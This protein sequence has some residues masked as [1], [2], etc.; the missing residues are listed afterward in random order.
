METL[1]I[2]L[3]PGVL[4]GIL[5][6]LLIAGWPIRRTSIVVPRRLDNASPALIN[7]A[8]IKVEGLGGLG[9]VAAV[10][11]VAIAD[12]RIRTAILIAAVLG[13]G[14]AALL[15]LMRRRNGALP[16]STGGPD[17]RSILHLDGGQSRTS[18]PTSAGQGRGD[19][20]AYLACEN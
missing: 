20:P 6:A 19:R 18:T 15:I 4:G 13:A 2:V 10:I 14:L 7:M 11:A 1:V 5:L 12:G 3:V 9:L 16:S 8:H 17:D